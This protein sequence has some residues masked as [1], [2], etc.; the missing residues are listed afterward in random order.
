MTDTGEPTYEDA[1]LIVRLGELWFLGKLDE[2]SNFTRSSAF[3]STYGAFV[4]KYPPGSDEHRK[5][6]GLCSWYET[7]GTLFKHGL[8]NRELLF[9][10]LAVES[11]WER[12]KGFAV[13]MRK[14][15]KVPR[16]WENFELMAKA[17]PH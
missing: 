16:L 2:A 6:V 1:N 8:L 17:E 3:R 14:E 5:V 15:A 13:G 12:L 7:V 10:W 9:D 11:T 4:K